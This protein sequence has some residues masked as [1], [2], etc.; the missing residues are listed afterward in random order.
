MD[1]KSSWRAAMGAM[2]A[3]ALCGAAAAQLVPPVS[4][5]SLPS[6]PNLGG[7]LNSVGQ[8]GANALGRANDLTGSA[9]GLADAR[10]ARLDAL[11]RANRDTLEMTDLGPAVRG[12][13]IAVDPDPATVVAALQAGFTR[14]GEEA[15]EGLE[16][17]EVTL[18]VPRG[19]PV[20]R[21]LARLRRIAPAGAF[22]ANHLHGQSGTVAAAGSAALA[23][24]R[25]AAG[26][27]AVGIIDGG[28]AAHPALAGPIEQRGFAAGAPAPSAH[29]TA[30]ASLVAGR[31]EMRSAAPG[32]PLLVADIYG[33][34]PTGGNALAL[35]RA[36][37]WMVA[38]RV[39]VVAISLVGPVNPLVARAVA[40]AES[41]GTWIVA[42]VGNDGRAAPPAYPAS[43]PGV[44]AVTGVDAR[45]RVLIEAGRAS[46]LDYA[47]PGADL[48][49]AMPGGRFAAVRG[50]SF[51]VPLVAGRL[52]Y[53]AR[54]PRPLAALDGE[55]ADRTRHDLGR[56]LICGDCRTVRRR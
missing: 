2:I 3:L 16:M 9:G 10:V 52:A 48:T 35:V 55:A 12:E 1:S 56:G 17:R 21:A 42:A 18:G 15:I 34:D 33:R 14:L 46:H 11:V 41:R 53:Y 20:D 44:I 45:D 39:P 6:T 23:Q 28:V 43:Y 38:R 24:A 30:V 7:T 4:A 25:P 27:S 8:A 22:T 29:G 37:G 19:W 32:A 13:V 5:P 31:G 49:A 40:Q 47:A 36:L 26:P 54:A 50:T 51:A